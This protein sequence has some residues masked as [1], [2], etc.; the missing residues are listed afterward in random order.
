MIFY[1]NRV[2]SIKEE[3]HELASSVCSGIGSR[4]LPEE[5]LMGCNHLPLRG[6]LD[7]FVAG[8]SYG[9]VA[10]EVSAHTVEL[11]DGQF[12]DVRI[13]RPPLGTH[14]QSII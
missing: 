8:L 9:N 5:C 7:R 2:A 13:V 3:E 1:R 4:P 10:V 6:L 12:S 14:L 11:P